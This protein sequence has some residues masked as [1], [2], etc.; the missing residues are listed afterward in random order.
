MFSSRFFHSRVLDGNILVFTILV[1]DSHMAGNSMDHVSR[2][3]G[4]LSRRLK[5]KALVDA[6]DSF[7]QE[8][9]TDC[10]RGKCLGLNMAICR[11]V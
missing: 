3:L 2:I 11:N 6:K 8:I 5:M 9:R 10:K 1:V 4:K 7:D